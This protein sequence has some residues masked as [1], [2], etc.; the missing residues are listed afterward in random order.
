MMKMKR[1]VRVGS[2]ALCCA[3]GVSLLAACTKNGAPQE[4]DTELPAAPEGAVVD[5]EGVNAL[6]SGGYRLD[7]VEEGNGYLVR[8]VDVSRLSN[9]DEAAAQEDILFEAAAPAGVTVMV[10]KTLMSHS[11]VDVSAKYEQISAQK[12][13]YLCTAT[14]S[15]ENGSQIAFSDR[16]YL[17]DG[18]FALAR[19]AEVVAVGQGDFGFQTVYSFGSTDPQK[20]H[21]EFDYF[22]PSILYKDSRD[23]AAG[24]PGSNLGVPKMYVKETRT[25][26][27]LSM[28]RDKETGYSIAIAHLEP[29]INVNGKLYGGSDGNADNDLQYGSIGYSS[30]NGMSVDFCYPC[31]EV[32][33]NNMRIYHEITK[34]NAHE[35]KLSILP[36]HQDSYAKSMTNTFKA[37]FAA[38][39]PAVAQDVD[40]DAIYDDNI[41]VFTNTYKEFD[42]NGSIV[43][44]GVPFSLDL[45]T[46]DT[47]GD[48]SSSQGYSFQFGFIGQQTSIAFNL[49]RTGIETGDAE[50]ER[51]GRTMLAFWSSS[52]VMSDALPP[53]WWDPN[54]GSST[55]PGTARYYPSF[56]RCIVDGLE[57]MLDACVWA[58]NN[59]VSGYEAWESALL[60][61]GS[62][63]AEHQNDDGSYYRAYRTNGTVWQEASDPATYQGTSK[64][65]TPVAIRLL[66]RLY[67]Y[68]G[69]EK[70]SAAAEKAAEF[71][72][73]NLY[74]DR[75][76]YVGGTPDNPNTVDKEAAIYALYG[77]DA[78]Y[79][80]TGEQKYLDAA[81]H[82]AVSALSWV[83][84]Y[85]F[86]VPG[87]VNE[88][89]NT[90]HDGGVSGFSL[91]ATGHSGAD[92]YSAVL[93]YEFFKMYLHTGD[94][95]Y[96]D[97]AY[98]LQQNTKL[99]SD[100]NGEIGYAF[101]ALC[102]EATGV[103]DFSL[104]GS[105]AKLWLVWCGVVN[106]QPIGYMRDTFGEADI[107]ALASQNFEQLKGQLEAYGSGGTLNEE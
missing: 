54:N 95:F 43:E 90:F 56:L 101:K 34:G 45:T 17:Q 77:F 5:K 3:L 53:S 41:E 2:L 27:P 28:L 86:A 31:A 92:N 103:A 59:G 87:G 32:P 6:L 106:I 14:V 83:Y 18:T 102:P 40:I 35:Y 75:E 78:A 55:T 11:A 39:S 22:I 71:S 84:C 52:K 93:Y 24:A 65:N 9:A 70:Y 107:A 25:G 99:S 74:L 96:R 44:A 46:P 15:T 97:A 50:M 47:Y 79:E 81:E 66:V 89:I 61:V 69:E 38:E 7:F 16:Y 80:L 104:G 21:T 12:Y 58:R 67:E 57:G 29:Q 51:Q 8:L 68:T 73:N 20:Q 37:A 82:A 23:M 64:L 1:W 94:E 63:L 19:R 33:L 62:W 30:E 85:D 48:W 10:N 4:D 105:G 36:E 98:F 42:V 100:Y 91:I 88:D 13:G 76:K 60:K 26:L 49:L 72:Y